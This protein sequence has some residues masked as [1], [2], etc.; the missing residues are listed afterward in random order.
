[1]STASE[2]VTAIETALA[3]SPG[4]S[5]IRFKDGKS[6]TYRSRAEMIKELAYWKSQVSNSGSDSGGF[7]FISTGLKGEY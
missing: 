4:V 1:M 5:S 3:E 2:M 7:N 6:I